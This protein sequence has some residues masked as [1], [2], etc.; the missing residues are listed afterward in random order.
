MGALR[1]PLHQSMEWL[2]INTPLLTREGKNEIMEARVMNSSLDDIRKAV[3][4]SSCTTEV[5]STF[6]C[7]EIELQNKIGS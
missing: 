4:L 6:K 2:V 7:V 5:P 1:P 3:V